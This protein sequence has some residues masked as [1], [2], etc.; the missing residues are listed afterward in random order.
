ME[1][2]RGIREGGG[3]SEGDREGGGWLRGKGESERREKS[4]GREGR[5][6]FIGR[7]GRGVGVGVGVGAGG[8]IYKRIRLLPEVDRRAG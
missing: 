1:G 6:T 4:V 3:G 2:E 8:A 5:V 7:G